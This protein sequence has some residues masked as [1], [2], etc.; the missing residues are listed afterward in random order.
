M[1]SLKTQINQIAFYLHGSIQKNT[2]FEG[3]SQVGNR[4][5]SKILANMSDSD[6]TVH[7]IYR[8]INL[9]DNPI[10]STA[11]YSSLHLAHP[12][13]WISRPAD[14]TLGHIARVGIRVCD[15]C[16]VT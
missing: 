14:R 2:A 15:L 4:S 9:V 10:N 12:F 3:S 11:R 1:N 7:G 8:V 16:S 6:I 5:K 13:A